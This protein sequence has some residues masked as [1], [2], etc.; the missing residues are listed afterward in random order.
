MAGMST[1]QDWA[2]QYALF[3]DDESESPESRKLVEE[4]AQEHPKVDLRIYVDGRGGDSERCAPVLVA[5]TG[6]NHEG[7]RDIQLA[8]TCDPNKTARVVCRFWLRAKA[9]G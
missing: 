9:T 6:S 4:W 3:I 8:L 7:L 5:P 1:R 2:Y